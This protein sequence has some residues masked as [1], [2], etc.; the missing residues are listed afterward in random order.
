[1]S[2]EEKNDILEEIKRLKARIAE[3]EGML[4]SEDDERQLRIE[5][6]EEEI[7]KKEK[8]LEDA[9]TREVEKVNKDALK[10]EKNLQMV[11]ATLTLST[12]VSEIEVTEELKG[13]TEEIKEFEEEANKISSELSSFLAEVNS[14]NLQYSAKE[15]KKKVKEFKTRLRDLKRLQIEK[16][17]LRVEISV[18]ML[19]SY[20]VEFSQDEEMMAL[21]NEFGSLSKVDVLVNDWRQNSYLSQLNYRALIEFSAKLKIV[22]IKANEKRVK[23]SLDELDAK[24]SAANDRILDLEVL[25]TEEFSVKLVETADNKLEELSDLLMSIGI[26]I[27]KNKEYIEAG[28]YNEYNVKYNDFMQSYLFLQK[29]IRGMAKQMPQPVVDNTDDLSKTID[30]FALEVDK[31]NFRISA[32]FGNVYLTTTTI[33]ENELSDLDNKYGDIKQDIEKKY[34]NNLI[35][36]NQYESMSKRMVAIEEQ[37]TYA[38]LKLNDPKMYIMSESL[39]FIFLNGKIDGVEKTMELLEQTIDKMEK[40]I[41]DRKT[42]KEIDAI[43]KK[44][45]KEIK[46]LEKQLEENRET[47]PVQYKATKERLNNNK[48]RLEALGKKYR[49]KCPLLVRAVKSAKHFFKKYKKVILLVAG[50][51]AFGMVSHSVI[52]PAIMHGNIMLGGLSPVLRGP[53]NAINN[54]LGGLIGATRSPIGIWSLANGVEINPLAASSSLLKGLA[55][56]GVG[57]AAL[58]APV[59]VMV[60]KLISKMNA[61][62]LKQK[63]A[64]A[65]D[66][67]AETTN[68]VVTGTREKISEVKDDIKD[69]RANT[70]ARK[71]IRNT[72][73]EVLKAYEA[74]DLTAE[75]Y[76]QQNNLDEFWLYF[77]KSY[78]SKVENNKER[79]GGRK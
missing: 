34:K 60:K 27:E 70:Q 11:K 47:D 59:V 45:E 55:I 64:A 48:K 49:R 19:E 72:V 62:E 4:E 25:L 57:T 15:I 46:S 53:I 16:Y 17:N 77:L 51:V 1:M 43:F 24:F 35:D 61:A 12:E 6:L 5:E 8:E 21:I 75:E 79:K 33:F 56:S 44:L 68:K 58:V 22:E 76:C 40:P 20:R 31:F 65:K 73:R 23:R 52:I 67:V 50:L 28:K 38:R 42:R 7:D 10:I 63:L 13:L 71:D 9:L 37:L 29:K 66:K 74:S 78:D 14:E 2:N 32:L 69:K 41:K 26:D 36:A 54:L 3:L 39:V 18:K 30:N